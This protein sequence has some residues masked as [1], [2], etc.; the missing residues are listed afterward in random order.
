MCS[1]ALARKA[2]DNSNSGRQPA[3]DPNKK[4]NIRKAKGGIKVVILMYLTCSS[5]KE[6]K[7]S[8]WK[9]GGKAQKAIR[10]KPSACHI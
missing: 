1:S 7:E 6:V 4:K 5:G 2:S 3:E 8:I 9:S 10:Q